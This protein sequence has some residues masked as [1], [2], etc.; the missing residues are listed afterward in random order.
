MPRPAPTFWIFLPAK[1]A[2]PIQPM[3]RT[4]PFPARTRWKFQLLENSV[5]AVVCF[6]LSFLF[7]LLSRLVHLYTPVMYFYLRDPLEQHRRGTFIRP[8][9]C[10][11][12]NQQ[13]RV[14]HRKLSRLSA[15]FFSFYFIAL[16]ATRSVF[17][18]VLERTVLK[19]STYI[20]SV[21]LCY[22]TKNFRV[23]RYC[24]CLRCSPL[25]AVSSES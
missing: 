7:V 13:T 1:R 2:N 4:L 24:P 18:T 8:R 21:V 10:L 6:R 5:P 16:F 19:T 25:L 20:T 3:R 17:I 14:S 23:R 22:S 11:P 9:D 15:F 12:R